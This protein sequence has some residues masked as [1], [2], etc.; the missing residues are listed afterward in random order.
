MS[1]PTKPPSRRSTRLARSQL[2]PRL[3]AG[4]VANKLSTPLGAP[5]WPRHGTAATCG[6]VQSV[7]DEKFARIGASV[8]PRRHPH[9]R[10]RD[11]PGA[12]HDLHKENT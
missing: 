9:A 11:Y 8:S 4:R 1:E 3:R 5:H 12:R 7:V 2:E 6:G 10:R